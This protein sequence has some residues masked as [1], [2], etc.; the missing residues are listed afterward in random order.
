MDVSGT[1]EDLQR[2]AGSTGDAYL[3]VTVNTGGPV[4]NIL[5]SVRE[6][7]PNAVDVRVDY[8]RPEAEERERHLT[9]L[10]PLEQYLAYYRS[11]H[12][13]EPEPELVATFNEVLDLELEA[14]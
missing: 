2:L 6:I 14:R 8:P 12:G 10:A 4:P 3:R 7:L 13:A 9:S 1:L 11:F 5:D